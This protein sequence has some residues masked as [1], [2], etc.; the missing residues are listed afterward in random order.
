MGSLQPKRLPQGCTVPDTFR[1]YPEIAM[2]VAL[3]QNFKLKT[4]GEFS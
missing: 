4:L 2:N 3:M 1:L